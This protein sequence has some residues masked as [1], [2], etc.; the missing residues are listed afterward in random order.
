MCKCNVNRKRDVEFRDLNGNLL[1]GMFHQWGS[2]VIEHAD[3]IG[4]FTVGICEDSNG[5][6]HEIQPSKIKFV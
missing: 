6:I 2:D 4:Q 3:Q 5:K 1:K